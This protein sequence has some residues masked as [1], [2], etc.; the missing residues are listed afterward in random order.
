MALVCLFAAEL[1]ALSIWIDNEVLRSSAGLA[2]LIHDWGAWTVRL[3]VAVAFVALIFGESKARGELERI[4]ETCS[5]HGI[6][7]TLVGGHFAVMAGFVG[8]SS[9]MFVN[10]TGS[11]NELAVV[12]IL[13]GLLAI[14]LAAC[15]LVPVSIW[16]DLIRSTGDG[17]AFALAA[18]LMACVLGEFAWKLWGPL[19]RWTLALV[20]LMLAPIVPAL[21]VDPAA[22][23][24]GTPGFHVEIAPQCSGYE[25]M[26]LML[27]FSTA[28]LWFLRREWRFPN[29]LLLAPAGVAAMFVLNAGRIAT[30]I[31][32]G[33]AGA[34]GIALGGFH[35]QAGWL[36]FNG[37]A[38]VMCA[39]A[40]RIPWL[41]H[42]EAAGEIPETAGRNATAAYLMPFLA[43]LA[44]AMIARASSGDFEWIYPLRVVAA[45]AALW[46]FRGTYKEMNWRIGWTGI[47]AGVLVFAI[48]IG[49]E[50]LA[51]AHATSAQTAALTAAP[52]ALMNAAASARIAWIIFRILGAVVTVPLAEEIAFR[53]FLMRRIASSDFES[54]SLKS[55]AWVPFLISSAA[56][57][58]LHG[59][60]WLAGMIAGMLY[61]LAMIRKGRIGDA[62]VAHAVTNA[63]VA[64]WVL[65]GGNWQLW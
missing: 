41:A 54:V 31:L 55:F 42:T 19:S 2:G 56:F 58:L 62:V 30:L 36:A 15:A 47:A 45:G 33:N 37:V 3:A 22:F 29:A 7:W 34:P 25:G 50:P 24:I 52:A 57:G 11:A 14:V 53:G 39:G 35:S 49:L 5:K 9:R 10:R 65:A 59:D 64:I 27:A 13:T 61:A 1:I 20:K 23:S 16:K 4:S 63:L 60:R 43:I 21:Y 51:R 26:G 18:G 6:S 32:I 12:W 40:R 48:W 46:Y 44:A 8:L 28:W 38:L 17:L